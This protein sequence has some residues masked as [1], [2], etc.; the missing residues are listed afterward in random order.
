MLKVMKLD[1]AAPGHHSIAER[2]T[3]LSLFSQSEGGYI[4][5]RGINIYM[6]IY[7]GS[8]YIPSGPSLYHGE[9]HRL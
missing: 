2:R 7:N 9:E 8:I 3:D 6:D 1:E 5:F 4:D